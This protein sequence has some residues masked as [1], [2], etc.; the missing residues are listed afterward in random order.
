MGSDRETSAGSDGRSRCVHVSLCLALAQLLP[1]RIF[2]RAL[3]LFPHITVYANASVVYIS[4]CERP[5]ITYY[6]IN[7]RTVPYVTA[8]IDMKNP[9]AMHDTSGIEMY[10][11]AMSCT[12]QELN[13][14]FQRIR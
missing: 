2:Y 1:E 14:H 11:S 5:L 6:S 8:A 13:L 7:D 3:A 9:F 12:T 10:V 4:P